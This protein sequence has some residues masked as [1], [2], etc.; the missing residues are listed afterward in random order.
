MQNILRDNIT[1]MMQEIANK[2]KWKFFEYTE[3]TGGGIGGDGKPTP[4]SFRR[5]HQFLI[6]FV[7]IVNEDSLNAWKNWYN[8]D[9]QKAS[10]DVVDS[11][12]QA[13]TEASQDDNRQKNMDSAMYYA[14]QKTKYANDHATEY[15]KALLSN[16]TKA[17]KKYENDMKK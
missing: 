10:N 12:K 17:E 15:Q 13:G 7:F 16:D 9:L 4:Y 6:S 8:N 2:K 14:D 5:P 11:Y 1:T 3:E